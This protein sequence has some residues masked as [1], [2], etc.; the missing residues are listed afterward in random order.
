MK[1]QKSKNKITSIVAL[2]AL[3]IVVGI[4][5]ALLVNNALNIVQTANS[6]V[7]LIEDNSKKENIEYGAEPVLVGLAATVGE[8]QEKT[9]EQ[10]QEEERLKQEQEEKAKEEE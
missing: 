7:D 6:K 9:E 1:K 10:K 8:Q 4:A 2:L 3:V 5:T